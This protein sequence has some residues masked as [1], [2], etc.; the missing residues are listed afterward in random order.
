MSSRNTSS[1]CSASVSGLSISLSIVRSEY[2]HP[3]FHGS[4]SI[5]SVIPALVPNLAYDDLEIQEGN[6]AATSYEVLITGNV[7]EPD[8]ASVR[9]AL[10]EYCRRDTEA[11]VRVYEAL[12]VQ[13]SGL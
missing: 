12:V 5:K 11:M 3:D 4:F 2:Y 10:L 7:P 9:Q 13:A 8:A 1:H 6:A